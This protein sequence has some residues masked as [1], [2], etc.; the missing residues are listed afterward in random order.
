[1]ARENKSL[2]EIDPA[3][4]SMVVIDQLPVIIR[5]H[6]Q[7]K[8]LFIS[9]LMGLSVADIND[10]VVSFYLKN[11]SDKDLW[12]RLLKHWNFLKRFASIDSHTLA[13]TFAPTLLGFDSFGTDKAIT[14]LEK[15]LNHNSLQDV[16]GESKSLTETSINQEL[17]LASSSKLKESSAYQDFIMNTTQTSQKSFMNYKKSEDDDENDEIDALVAPK[18]PTGTGNLKNYAKASSIIK[19]PRGNS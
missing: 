8:C 19:S 15:I 13:T 14:F 11:K 16:L 6:T 7:E 2:N 1:M 10:V 3:E 18:T 5:K 12:Q 4:V 17:I 9:D